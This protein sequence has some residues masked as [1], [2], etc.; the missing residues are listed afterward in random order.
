VLAEEGSLQFHQMCFRCGWT[1]KNIHSAFDYIYNSASKDAQCGKVLGNWLRNVNGKLVGGYPPSTEDIETE[2]DKVFIF[3]NHLFSRQQHLTNKDLK[4]LLIGSILRWE[5][6][7]SLAINYDPKQ[8][9]KHNI[10]G[11][12]YMAEIDKAKQETGK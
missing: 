11:H 4:K 12:P 6:D 1:T 8:Q 7:V 10:K 3:S 5:D 2:R 9:Y